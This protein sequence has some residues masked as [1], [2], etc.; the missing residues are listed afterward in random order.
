V[1]TKLRKNKPFNFYA[2]QVKH[3]F[4]DFQSLVDLMTP[5]RYSKWK[6]LGYSKENETYLYTT[7]YKEKKQDYRE[8]DEMQVYQYIGKVNIDFILDNAM[9]LNLKCDL[10]NNKLVYV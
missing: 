5:S 1:K 4:K 8:L 9:C 6:Y 7:K 2:F 3:K 10:T